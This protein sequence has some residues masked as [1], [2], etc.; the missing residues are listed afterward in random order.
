MSL[1][2]KSVLNKYLKGVDEKQVNEAWERFKSHFHNLA[3]QENIRSSKE[4]QH[5]GEFL[6][7]LFVKVLG[8]VNHPH[9]NYNL[10]REQKNVKDLKTAD[11]AIIKDGKVIAVIELKGTGTTNL[12]NI[13]TQAFGYKNNQPDAVYVI[14]SNFEKLRFY[15]DNVVYFEDFNLF[16][17]TKEE[18]NLLWLCLSKESIFNGI[19][20][21]IKNESLTEEANVT[22]KLYKDY[23]LFKQTLFKDIINNNRKHDKLLLFK[24]TQK[25]LDRFLFIFFAEDKGLLPP[26]S[27]SKILNQWDKLKELDAYQPLYNRFKLYFGYLNS[28]HKGKQHD[29]FA[30]NGG[31]FVPD[32][33]LDNLIITDNLLYTHCRVLSHYDYDTEVDTNILGHIFEHSLNELDEVAAVSQGSSL[34]KTKT[35]RKKD[36]I[37][38]TPRYITKYIVENTVGEL[39]N[40]KKM[41]F[42]LDNDA[43]ISIDT[44]KYRKMYQ[45]KIQEYRNWLL[46]L[47]I[48]DPACGSG[49]FLNQALE[50]LVKEHRL[51]DDMTAMLFGDSLVMTDN[52]TEILENNIFGVD[53]NEESVEIARLSLWLRTAKVGRK[54]NDLSSNIKCGD[55]LISDPLVAGNLAFDWQKE[56]P[57]VFENGGFDIII[58]NPPYVGIEDIEWATRRYYETVFISA[59]GRF[60]LYSLF[61]ER[62][63]SIRKPNSLFGFIIPAKFLNNKQFS[64]TRQLISS[65]NN[66]DIVLVDDKVFEEASVNSV[67]I[68]SFPQTG[69]GRYRAYKINNKDLKLISESTMGDILNSRESVFRIEISEILDLLI[70]KIEVDTI[71]VKDIAEVKDGIVAGGIKD[72][73]FM[74]KKIDDDSKK[75]YFG[76][77]ISKYYLANTEI[78]VNYKPEEM[79]KEEVRR[80]GDKRAGLWMRDKKIFEREKIIYRKVGK[81]IIATFAEKG[82]FYEQTVHSCFIKDERFSIKY[83]LALFNSKLFKFYYRKK[84]SQ[85]GDI[86]PQV[87]I[88]SVE[89]LPIKI[90][91]QGMQNRIIENAKTMLVLNKSL[92]EEQVSFFNTIKEEKHIQRIPSS[93][94]SID[95]ISFEQFKNVLKAVKVE[96]KLGDDNNQ[97]RDYFK[98]TVEKI[99]QI[100]VEIKKVDK[101]IDQ[102][103]YELYELTPE[104]I[105]IVEGR[106]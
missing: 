59:K 60:D 35:K 34:D 19:P 96:F 67:I 53:I 23:S 46:G 43:L 72:I 104:E 93:L 1:F 81:E 32:E 42:G 92:Y 105:V 26:N 17:L 94:N 44:K 47:T 99:S 2:Q 100:K 102:L 12:G 20:K 63:L 97:W 54:L 69:N 41:E 77:N 40:R 37:F 66:I 25:L 7:D 11:G 15:I 22:K 83:I 86:F 74:E 78:W 10:I 9:E 80:Q 101:Q 55:S 36:G 33:F 64:T 84:N 62:S 3:I 68:F 28:G 85:G 27:V 18:F 90:T 76:K 51:I 91:S 21:Q 4:E 95:E 52:V 39:C 6:I 65:K 50:F 70:R 88:S 14:T 5:Q 38:Y 98:T 73:L 103:V 89:N 106:S 79:M 48:C 16:K 30:Y 56:F 82:I 29:I 58:G 31:L 71:K 49:A 57:Q 24:K 75:L 45:G 13:E 87:R 8:Y 61:I